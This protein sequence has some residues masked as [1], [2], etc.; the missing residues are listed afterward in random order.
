MKKKSERIMLSLAV[1][2][3]SILMLPIDTSAQSQDVASPVSITSSQN[4]LLDAYYPNA[5]IIGWRYKSE[6]GKMYRRQY[7]Y[8][9]EKWIGEWEL[10]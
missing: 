6:D 7:N 1:L 5:N 3:V 2:T 9:R 10:C 8:S 4:S